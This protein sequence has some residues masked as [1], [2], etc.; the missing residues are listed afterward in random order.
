MA[1]ILIVDDHPTMRF[2][3]RSILQSEGHL[4]LEAPDGEI[5]LAQ[6]AEHPDV[7]LL[8]TDLEMPIMSGFELLRALALRTALPK[9]VISGCNPKPSLGELGVAEYFCKPLNLPHFKNTVAR[10]LGGQTVSA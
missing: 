4:T 9:L 8:V 5:A 2:L 10:L 1:T 3:L 6:L 7:A